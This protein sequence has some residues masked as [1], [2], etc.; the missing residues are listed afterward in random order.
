MRCPELGV[1][2]FDLIIPAGR[3]RCVAAALDAARTSWAAEGEVA[4]VEVD[5]RWGP[6]EDTT[7][8]AGS[9]LRRAARHLYTKGCYTGRGRARGH[10]WAREPSLARLLKPRRTAA[11]GGKW[12][13][14][15]PDRWASS[16][17]VIVA[18]AGRIALAMCGRE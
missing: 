4:R 12:S 5:A 7:N 8:S 17:G 2:G 3:F 18:T 15:V 10:S 11:D 1:D 9:K 14:K 16:E 13:L 6:I